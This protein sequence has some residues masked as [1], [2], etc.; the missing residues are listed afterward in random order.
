MYP[1]RAHILA[2]LPLFLVESTLE[3]PLSTTPPSSPA[4]PGLISSNIPSSNGFIR[5]NPE[6]SYFWHQKGKDLLPLWPLESPRP[7]TI[8]DGGRDRVILIHRIS[9][10]IDNGV[11]RRIDDPNGITTGFTSGRDTPDKYHDETSNN[12]FVFCLMFLFGLIICG[13]I[14][15]LCTV[16]RHQVDNGDNY[17]PR[18]MTSRFSHR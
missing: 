15:C 10:D 5:P 9:D 16:S 2:L 17:G 6:I 14:W 13:L 18:R 1:G 4:D 11:R 12:I 8:K 7:T 3:S